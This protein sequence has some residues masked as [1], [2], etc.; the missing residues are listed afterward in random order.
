MNID[1]ISNVASPPRSVLPEVASNSAR[2]VN[3][4]AKPSEVEKPT[5]VTKDQGQNSPDKLDVKRAVEKISEFVSSRQSELSFS[6]DDASGSQ[7]VKI[8]DTQTKQVIRQFPSEE[9]VAIAQAL[10]KLQGLLIRDKA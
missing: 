9:A 2:Q 5:Q 1:M 4:Q 10:D 8:M 6:I 3:V 7:I